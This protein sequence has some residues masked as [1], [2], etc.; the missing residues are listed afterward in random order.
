MHI[1][2]IQERL[3]RTDPP[4][5]LTLFN[6]LNCLQRYDVAQWLSVCSNITT[7]FHTIAIFKRFVK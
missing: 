4:A 5:S 7:E 6:K 2:F 1:N 3:E